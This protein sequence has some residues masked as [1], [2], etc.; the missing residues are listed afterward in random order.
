[1][2]TET[3][4]SIRAL[5]QQSAIF[6]LIGP[7]STHLSTTSPQK[8]QL[9]Q[10]TRDILLEPTSVFRKYYYQEVRRAICYCSFVIA[11]GKKS[12]TFHKDVVLFTLAI[13]VNRLASAKQRIL[14]M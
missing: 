14:T 12:L 1:M 2:D 10:T 3:K 8:A 6:Q 13:A 9:Y 4:C 11:Q 7:R 5:N